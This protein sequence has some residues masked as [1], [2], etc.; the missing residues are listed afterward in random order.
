MGKLNLVFVG[1]LVLVLLGL[2]SAVPETSVSYFYSTTC[3]HCKNVADSGVL[4]RIGLMDGVVVEEYDIADSV[5]RD[6]YLEFIGR[7]EVERSGIPFLVI[8]QGG[9]FSYL[10]GDDNIIGG[11]EDA[12][13]NFEGVDVGGWWDVEKITLGVVVVA[14]LVDSINPCAFGVLL[15]LM[16]S[17]L[18]MGSAK[19]AL[20]AGLVYSF[21]VFLVYF[22]VG[23]GIFR[24]IDSF[25]NLNHLI[26][27]VAGVLLLVL[28]V[29]QFKDV[30]FPRFGPA[31]QISSKA[32]PIIEKI[33]R[34]GTIPAMIVLGVFVSLFE[35]PC[36]GGIYL[37]ILSMMSI[38][39]SFAISYLV[40]YNLIFVLPL[41]VLTFLIYRGMS[42]A[43]LQRWTLSERKWMKIGSGVVLVLLGIWILFF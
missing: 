11:L 36:T 9:E 5:N 34:R 6:M 16:L 2:V 22:F 14:A 30:F 43:V 15:F 40:L 13:V 10:M 29:W 31:L 21:V 1:F 20:K 17:L 39:K 8:E 25:Q 35:L 19:R 27:L 33:I 32:K 23:L 26:Y 38:N 4:D 7:F 3:S 37:G 28:G 24:A 41:V 18:N 42:P 12:V